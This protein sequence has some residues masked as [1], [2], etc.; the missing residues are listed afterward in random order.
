M[1]SQ[2]VKMNK[3]FPDNFKM[4]VV[5]SQTPNIISDL[6]ELEFSEQFI[7]QYLKEICVAIFDVAEETNS[8]GRVEVTYQRLNP[9]EELLFVGFTQEDDTFLHKRIVG[10]R[11]MGTVMIKKHEEDR[12]HKHFNHFTKKAPPTDVFFYHHIAGNVYGV[13]TIEEFYQE[14]TTKPFKYTLM[15]CHART[16]KYNGKKYK[17]LTFQIPDEELPLSRIEFIFGNMVG[18][19]TY[20]ISQDNWNK[21]KDGIWSKVDKIETEFGKDTRHQ[22]GSN[23]PYKKDDKKDELN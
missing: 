15:D 14:M 16:F 23:K 19:M 17:R 22:L 18:G 9:N 21:Y 3:T 10:D 13:N 20:I 6:R 5:L 2:K 7:K 4:K 11:G 8:K 12:F 1:D